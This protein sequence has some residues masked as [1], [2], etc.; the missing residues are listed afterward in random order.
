[1]YTNTVKPLF[2]VSEETLAKKKR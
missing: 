2:I 1:L